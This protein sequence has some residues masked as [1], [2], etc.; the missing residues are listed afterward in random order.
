[1]GLKMIWLSFAFLPQYLGLATSTSLSPTVHDLSMY[2]PVPIGCWVPNVPDGWKTPF[3]STVPASALYFLRADGL[4]IPK[5]VSARAP[6]N[7]EERRVSMIWT[8]EFPFV[9]Q[10]L[11]RLLSGPGFPVAGW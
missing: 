5:F 7:D 6:R 10:P 3:A 2:G 4:A 8:T 1:M 9:L 11:Y